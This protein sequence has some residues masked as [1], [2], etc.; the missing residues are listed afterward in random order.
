MQKSNERLRSKVTSM[1]DKV[2]SMTVSMAYITDHKKQSFY[3][4]TEGRGPRLRTANSLSHQ[5]GALQS[6]L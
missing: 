5:V 2:C 3:V 6:L 1:L 4:V